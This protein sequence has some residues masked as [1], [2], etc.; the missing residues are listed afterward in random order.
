MYE[1]A[2]NAIHQHLIQK[3]MSANLVYT[4][5]LIPERHPDGRLYANDPFLFFSSSYIRNSHR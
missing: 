5:E 4:S 1:D 3:S 2:M